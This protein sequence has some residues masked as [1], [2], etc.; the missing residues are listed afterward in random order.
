[1]CTFQGKPIDEE[2]FRTK[3]AGRQNALICA[4]LFPDWDTATRE[5]WSADKE[6]AFRE[7]AKGTLRAMTGLEN[8]MKLIDDL[9]LKKAAVTNAPR[10]NAELMLGAIGRLEWFDT[11][12]IGD[13][14][15]RA[16]PDPMPYQLAMDRLGLVADE[17]MV[18]EDSPSGA[19]A[20]VAS[21]AW[22]VGILTSQPAEKLS[23]VGCKLLI[24]DYTDARFLQ[25]L[26]GEAPAPTAP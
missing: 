19:E 24:T 9:G 3:I 6:A 12:V 8:V 15:E 5:Q 26:K 25:V 13:E 2:F 4:D 20:G 1:M 16:K 11:I 10:P 18:V 14:C 23:K 22:T 17:C 21:G 7:K